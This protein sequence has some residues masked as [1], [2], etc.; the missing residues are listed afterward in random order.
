MTF[1]GGQ[2]KGRGGLSV[3]GWDGFR[4]VIIG[5]RAEQNRILKRQLE[6]LEED[7]VLKQRSYQDDIA[8]KRQI[9]EDQRIERRREAKNLR[10]RATMEEARVCM[11][12][13]PVMTF[14]EALAWAKRRYDEDSK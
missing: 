12:I 13:E 1:A 7:M 8:S 4:E 6:L 10:R 2:K 9:K 5:D 14:K 3:G 11:G